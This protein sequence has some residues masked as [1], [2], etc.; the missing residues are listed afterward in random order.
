[1]DQPF[2]KLRLGL[3][4]DKSYY[5]RNGTEDYFKKMR[6]AYTDIQEDT[7]SEYAYFAFFTLCSATLEYSLNFVLADYCLEQFGMDRYKTYLDEYIKLSFKNKLLLLPHIISNGKFVMNEDCFAFKR[8]AEMIHLRNQ[9][10]HNK[11]F[12]VEFDLPLN[13][14]VED[15]GLIVPEGQESI[16]FN[17]EMKDTPI[18]K[19][20]KENC[21]Y[22]GNAMGDFKKYLMTPALTDGLK[23]NKMI[24]VHYA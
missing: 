22:Y 6:A 7:T 9:L 14:K 1:M 20:N 21:I 8:L 4:G 11:E 5:L 15:G 18:Q 19:L 12:L 10:M 13:F 17:I 23:A 24:K 3:T 2:M 16:E